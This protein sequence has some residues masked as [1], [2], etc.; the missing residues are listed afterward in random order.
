MKRLLL[1]VGIIGLVV[2]VLSFLF[3][4]FNRFAYYHVLDGSAELYS[5][6]HRKMIV[7]FVIGIVLAVGGMVSF[8][9]RSK[10]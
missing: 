10:I 5:T 7:F 2:G 8:I 1:I 4:L 6:L 9:I 3:S